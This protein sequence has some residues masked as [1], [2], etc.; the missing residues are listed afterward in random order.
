MFVIHSNGQAIVVNSREDRDRV[1]DA[2]W[3]L[4][5]LSSVAV[6]VA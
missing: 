1:M 5:G 6:G 3:T 4:F 2:L